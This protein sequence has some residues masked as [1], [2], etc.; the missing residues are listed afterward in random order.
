MQRKLLF[1]VKS[2]QN[3]QT[4]FPDILTLILQEDERR[5]GKK[6]EGRADNQK[7]KYRIEILNNTRRYGMFHLLLFV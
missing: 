2:K 7:M 1:Q 3:P 6:K 4:Q 5:R